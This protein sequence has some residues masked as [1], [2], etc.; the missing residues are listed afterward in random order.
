VTLDLLPYQEIGATWLAGRNRS[1]LL[2][3]PGV[4]K[5]AQAIRAWDMLGV[6][7]AV[8]VAPAEAHRAGVWKNEY[9]KFGQRSLRFIKGNTEQDRDFWLRGKSDVL[10]LSY[11]MA[12][13]WAS[14]LK[15]DV[16]DCIVFDEAHRLKNAGAARTRALIGP[17]CNGR[18]GLAEWAVN[19]W[20]LTG[21]ANPND[22][23]DC[24]SM[25]RF[26]GATQLN[27]DAFVI[28][29]Y[30]KHQRTYSASHKP[31]PEMLGELKQ[32]IRS[33]S[34]RR[35]ET[36]T[37]DLRPPIF[38]TTT[39]LDGDTTEIR[40]LLAGHPRMEPAIKEAVEAGGLSFL[41]SQHV[42]TLRRLVGEAKAPPFA[43]LLVQE[44]QDGLQKVVVFGIHI[45]ALKLIKQALVDAGIGV[46][47]GRED[48]NAVERFQTDPA[49]RVFLGNIVASGTA[50]TL[51]AAAHV[52]MFE[53]S[54]A[55]M[56]NYQAIK[57]VHRKGQTKKV[58]AQWISLANSIDETVSA[59]LA[60]KTA[61]IAAVEG[62][63]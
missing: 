34:L 25:L 28:R 20:W 49:C 23:A 47:Y 31:R 29:Y 39:E 50:I 41:D 60:R 56:D 17:E 6:E 30:N 10:L 45:N 21:T 62:P 14:R 2:D 48:D 61:A 59:T 16:I 55:P 7:R 18:F 24:W 12:T 42:A 8:V 33:C 15:R 38:M 1:A 57:R 58:H 13:N 35:T 11:E 36:Q 26:C 37:G 51:T 4:G 52:I 19:G 54:W 3:E 5:T 46:V 43:V 53:S 9:A 63:R 40:A 32:V 44:L 27:K 22:A